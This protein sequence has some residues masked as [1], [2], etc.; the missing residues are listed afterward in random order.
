MLK[1]N[2]NL[3]L[4][5]LFTAFLICYVTFIL[6]NLLE[7]FNP[8]LVEEDCVILTPKLFDLLVELEQKYK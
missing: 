3:I 4:F 7:V 8:I 2:K 5:I 1:T 6:Y